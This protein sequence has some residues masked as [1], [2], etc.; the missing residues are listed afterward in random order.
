MIQKVDVKERYYYWIVSIL[1]IK[2]N[3]VL[4]KIGLTIIDMAYVIFLNININ[5]NLWSKIIL[6]ITY[7]KNVKPTF[8]L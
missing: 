4:E 7:A 2:V 3:R 6:A 5:K 1:L 8:L